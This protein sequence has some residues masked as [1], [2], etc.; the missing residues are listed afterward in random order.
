M[1]FLRAG[2]LVVLLA[3]AA[4]WA[5]TAGAQTD[6][7]QVTSAGPF[8]VAEGSVKVA[9]MT[10]SG[11]GEDDVLF[12]SILTDVGS[13]A[14]GEKFKLRL[15]DVLEFVEPPDFEDPGDDGAENT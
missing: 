8:T 9:Q 12:W 15:D 1:R 4:G 10:A 13:G 7:A 5:G 3:V 6:T 11:F 14:D 2:A